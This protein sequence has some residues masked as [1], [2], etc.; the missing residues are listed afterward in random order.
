MAVGKGLT[1][2]EVGAGASSDRGSIS[3]RPAGKK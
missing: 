3:G 1:R 2:G